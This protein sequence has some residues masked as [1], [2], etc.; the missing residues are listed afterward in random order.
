[1]TQF[2]CKEMDAFNSDDVPK[3]KVFSQLI[4][5][6]DVKHQ[7]GGSV[8]F[9][10][11]C[12]YQTGNKV[13]AACVFRSENTVYI[14][15]A[16]SD[17]LLTHSSLPMSRAVCL[18]EWFSQPIMRQQSIGTRWLNVDVFSGRKMSSR[19]S[20]TKFKL[21]SVGLIQTP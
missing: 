11:Q 16:C 1:M 19:S 21:S 14:H 12:C 13:V 4:L 3:F 17:R 6:F 15:P 2:V 9:L 20:I 8:V 7:I 10:S 5:I 18:F